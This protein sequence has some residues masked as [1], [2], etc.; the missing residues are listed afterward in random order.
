LADGDLERVIQH[1]EHMAPWFPINS[2]CNKAL[3][4]EARQTSGTPALYAACQAL[5]LPVV[6]VDGERDIRPRAA[7]DSL[8]RALPRVRRVT[9]AA[10]GHLPWV[11]DPYGFRDAVMTAAL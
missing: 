7:V 6:V 8:M 3:N 11:E 2:P 1:A 10:A 9:L 5:D 4:A